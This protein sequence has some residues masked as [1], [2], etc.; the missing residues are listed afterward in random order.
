MPKP[1][2]YETNVEPRTLLVGIQSPFNRTKNIDSYYAEFINLVKTFGAPYEDVVCI[3]LRTLDSAYF[4]SRGKLDQVKELCEKLSIERVILSDS[5]NT[6]QARNLHDYLECEVMDRTQLILEIFERAA[7]SAEGKTQVAIAQFQHAKTRL[8]GKGIFLEQQIGTPG[9][10]SGPGEKKKERDRR[11]IEE[12]ILK[13]KRQLEKMQHARETQRKK[14]IRSE[15]PLMCLIGYTNAGKSTILNTLTKSNV[16]AED[17]LFAT[18]DT[19]ISALYIDG[20]KKGTLSDTVG[21]IQQL[22]TH[23]IEAFKST[24]SELKYAD[25]L[26]QVVDLSDVNWREHIDVVNKILYDLALDQKMLYV[27]NKRDKVENLVEVMTQLEA[28]QPHVVTSGNTKDGLEPL[29]NFLRSWKKQ[30]N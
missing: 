11:H 8:A 15:E 29:I 17:K 7:V 14:R 30:Q 4:I 5:I 20:V 27:F 3:K 13:L 23:L 25:L 21:F 18:L 19:T 26:L 10:R 28:Y 12:Q 24:L 16:L 2:L 1:A 6:Q 9:Q 22:P